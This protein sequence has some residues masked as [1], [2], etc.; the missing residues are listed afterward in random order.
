MVMYM[1][2]TQNLDLWIEDGYLT[3]T[4]IEERIKAIKSVINI[5][6]EKECKYLKEEL[7]YLENTLR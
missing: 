1:A 6:D 3:E 5:A 4:A 2:P 7:M